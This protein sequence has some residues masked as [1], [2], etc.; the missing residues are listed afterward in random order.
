M[1]KRARSSASVVDLVTAFYLVACYTIGPLNKLIKKPYK[2][3]RIKVLLA[4]LVL[5]AAF[6]TWFILYGIIVE[7]LRAR[8]LVL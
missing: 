4:K 1:Y 2:L 3:R 6:R 5:E 8:Y 7:N